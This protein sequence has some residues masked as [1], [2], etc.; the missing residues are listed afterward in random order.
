MASSS[1]V[2]FLLSFLVLAMALSYVLS[3][4]YVMVEDVHLQDQAEVIVV[5]VCIKGEQ[6]A[7]A[8]DQPRALYTFAVQEVLKGSVSDN[9]L[10]NVDG[11]EHPTK[12]YT[13]GNYGSPSFRE[14]E[15]VIL[16]LIPSEHETGVFEI[17]HIFMGAFF[18]VPDSEG[19]GSFALRNIDDEK[20]TGQARNFELFKSWLN[21]AV[22]K[23]A[24]PA[25]WYYSARRSDLTLY[26]WRQTS[27]NKRWTLI[28]KGQ[29]SNTTHPAPRWFEFDTA[30]TVTWLT[31]DGANF[32][33][34]F[35][36]ALKSYSDLVGFTITYTMGGTTGTTS[37]LGG[38]D[39]KNTMAIG[40][41]QNEIAGSF[42]CQTGGVVGKGGPK[43][44][45]ALQTFRSIAFNPIVEADIVLQDGV[46]LCNFRTADLEEVLCHEAGHTLGLGHSCGDTDSGPCT[47]GNVQD[48]ALMRA[49]AHFD[50]RGPAI[51][52]DDLDG[53]E[54]LYCAVGVNCVTSTGTDDPAGTGLTGTATA[55]H[56]S[57]GSTLRP[58]IWG[59]QIPKWE[60]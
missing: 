3:L 2:S 45:N 27:T 31:Y 36:R 4:S 52:P 15:K 11:G 6:G 35:A 46:E 29:K 22:T 17:L 18:E 16:F 55:K 24:K 28:S 42:S 34:M 5:G 41:P 58:S 7:G 32:R 43:Y 60:W 21:E 44:T 25:A 37:G 9:V 54:Y 38:S 20:Y 48:E 40:D 12:G 47:T 50:N 53:L 56:S 13:L 26:N 49:L 33:T 39:N 59:I 1:R 10:V 51:N 8:R 14:N 23:R 19:K 57:S 30:Q